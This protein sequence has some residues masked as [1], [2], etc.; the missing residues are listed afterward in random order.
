MEN[1]TRSPSCYVSERP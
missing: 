1:K